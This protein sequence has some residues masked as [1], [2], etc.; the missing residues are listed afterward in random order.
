MTRNPQIGS[1]ES[2]ESMATIR[3]N[4]AFA[5]LHSPWYNRRPIGHRIKRSRLHIEDVAGR[6]RQFI[7]LGAC[8]EATVTDLVDGKGP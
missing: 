3:I 5:L 2:P 6:E 7:S 4:V 8:R 1:N